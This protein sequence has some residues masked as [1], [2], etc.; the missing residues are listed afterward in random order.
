MYALPSFATGR[1]M[2]LNDAEMAPQTLRGKQFNIQ[3]LESRN[4][5][6][7]DIESVSACLL[8]LA[9]HPR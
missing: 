8:P 4:S 2:L 3:P 1:V 6:H 9:L 5:Q 7:Q